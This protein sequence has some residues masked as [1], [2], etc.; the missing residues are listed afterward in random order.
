MLEL[1]QKGM[2]LNNKQITEVFGCQ[3]EGGIRKS[4]KNHLL[5]LINDLAQSLYQNRWE[6]DVFYF[7]AIGK[8]G[9]QSLETPW[10][11]RDLSQVNI[12]GQ[13]VF[14]FEKLKPAHYRFQGEVV[15]GQPVTEIQP[16]EAGH[17]REVFVFPVRL[18]S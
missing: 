17:D 11:N 5:V 18:K 13:R 16:D 3:F 7:T 2:V 10:Q 15:V 12:A 1:P 14:L 4:K 8:K 6:K 9:N